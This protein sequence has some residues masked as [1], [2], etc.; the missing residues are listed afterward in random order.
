MLSCRGGGKAVQASLS[1]PPHTWVSK[2][3]YFANSS[4]FKLSECEDVSIIKNN[5]REMQL[6]SL[7]HCSE[8]VREAVQTSLSCPPPT[9]LGIK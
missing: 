9:H 2:T 7:S 6:F 5:S 1:V 8:G 3:N 4:Y